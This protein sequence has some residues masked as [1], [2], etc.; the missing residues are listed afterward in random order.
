MDR[1]INYALQ[2]IPIKHQNMEFEIRFGKY[3]RVS[4]NIKQD[5]AI[6]VHNKA[7]GKKLYTFIDETFYNDNKPNTIRQRIYYTD[8]KHLIKQMFE[9]P[10][11][12]SIETIDKIIKTY[13]NEK[14]KRTYIS[15]SKVMHNIVNLYKASIDI[16]HDCHQISNYGEKYPEILKKYKFRCSIICELWIY[17]IT[18]LLINDVKT[19][20]TG[21]FYEIEI[22]YNNKLAIV[23]KAT[24]DEIMTSVYKKINF[25]T[26]I[27]SCGK[28]S[29]IEIEIKYSLF[30]AVQTMERSKLDLLTNAKYAVVDKADGERRFI[31]IDN[32]CSIWQYNPT[33][34]FIN[35]VLIL[36]NTKITLGGTLIDCEFIFNK[37][38]SGKP[39]KSNEGIFYGFDLLFFKNDD[40]RNYNLIERLKLLE[41]TINELNK[42]GINGSTYTYSMKKF[43]MDDIFKTSK[44]LWDNRAKLFN[45]NLDGLIFTP[46]RGGYI[47]NLPNLKYKP[48]VSID[49]R[50]F[51]NKEHNFTEF[52]TNG[53]PINKNGHIINSYTD[54]KTNQIYYKNKVVINDNQLKNMGV[55]NNLG[56]LG[57]YGQLEVKINDAN[58][59]SKIA[60]MID[61]V[62][63]EFD[64]DNKKWHFLRT[65]PDKETPNA[66]LSIKS[67]INAI[68]ENITI[69]ELSKLKYVKSQLELINGDNNVCATGAGF[70]FVSSDIK[71]P[72]C[73]FYRYS[74]THILNNLKC[75]SILVIGCNLCL[76]NGLIDSL[77]TDIT[78]IESN[79]LEVYGTVRSEGYQGLLETLKLSMSN[80]T[81][82]IVWGEFN[83]G[84][85]AF[86]KTGKSELSK[87]KKNIYDTVFISNF[88]G[89]IDPKKNLNILKNMAKINIIGIFLSGKQIKNYLNEQ[90]CILITN[91]ELHPLWKLYNTD[92][93]VSEILM[94]QNSFIP[95]YQTII[96]DADISQA[97]DGVKCN[98]FK[99]LKSGYKNLN[100]SDSIIANIMTYF[101]FII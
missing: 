78:I 5:T 94:L 1:L 99:T 15:K 95:I 14:Q 61:I 40:Y 31:Y 82:K 68:K 2:H 7:D 30:N 42:Y 69:Q 44:R 39:T 38:I 60:D 83:N 12:I 80:K 18:I 49:V 100:E 63:M 20:K 3:N 45:Y 93:D 23:N 81:I 98:S 48:L 51:Y 84:L 35:K 79:C 33:D 53:Y 22:E 29:N 75:K 6:K 87:L 19:N 71:S 43:Y 96:F 9:K 10:D 85:V 11:S 74:Y 34:A 101:T 37:N 25:I 17:D 57:V 52:Y 91:D 66:I 36:K 64:I 24:Y 16:E 90:D 50:V 72:I 92:K 62:E 32:N 8:T 54:N 59:F 65:R 89:I 13:S 4:S 67:A 46:I 86:S 47:G 77:Y 26:T 41:K 76:L 28:L 97:F 88:E 58:D 21:I 73:D 55:I 70:N 27:I 56:I